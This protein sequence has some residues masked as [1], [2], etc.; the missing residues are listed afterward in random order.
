MLAELGPAKTDTEAKRN[1][2]VA[3]RLV[4]SELGNT[5]TICRKSYVHPMVIARYLDDGE[6]IASAAISARSGERGAG[7]LAGGAGADRLSRQ[8]FSGAA[9]GG[10]SSERADRRGFSPSEAS[11]IRTF[12]SM[13]TSDTKS[14]R[15]SDDGRAVRILDQRQLPEREEYRELRTVDE[16][17]DAIATLAV[18]GAPAIGIAGAMGM[19]LALDESTATSSDDM[20]RLTRRARDAFAARARPR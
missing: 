7:A 3:M 8:T 15:W 10:V 12:R 14:I 13:P 11:D 18:R 4:S 20:R 16:V 2:A 19:V 17:C 6:T 1:V 9:E 5:A